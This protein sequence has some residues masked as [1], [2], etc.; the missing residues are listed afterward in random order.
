VGGLLRDAHAAE[1]VIQE[2]CAR[3]AAEVEKGASRHERELRSHRARFSARLL[4]ARF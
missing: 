3:L 2:V 1:D 4:H